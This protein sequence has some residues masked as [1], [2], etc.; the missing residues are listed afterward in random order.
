[1][2]TCAFEK[3]ITDYFL[4]FELPEYQEFIDRVTINKYR[5]REIWI[6]ISAK[7]HEKLND[8]EVRIEKWFEEY[9]QDAGEYAFEHLHLPP[10][11]T[12]HL[13]TAHPIT[14]N[15]GASIRSAIATT[16]SHSQNSPVP[17]ADKRHLHV[18]TYLDNKYGSMLNNA[19]II[20]R[21]VN[22]IVFHASN[23]AIRNLVFPFEIAYYV[24]QDLVER[25]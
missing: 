1:M 25:G 10:P 8:L 18:K 5:T 12:F 4:D 11:T 6:E 20:C 16:S 22:Y 14:A 3:L 23:G 2:G 15:C 17:N 21:S 24:I 19:S 7:V 9:S 13:A